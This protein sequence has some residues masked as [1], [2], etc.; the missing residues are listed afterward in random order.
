MFETENI[1]IQNESVAKKFADDVKKYIL[2]IKHRYSIIAYVDMNIKCGDY[3][4]IESTSKNI[5]GTFY[6]NGLDFDIDNVYK[7]TIDAIRIS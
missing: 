3:I 6:I 1:Y 2:N 4:K 5:S 7:V